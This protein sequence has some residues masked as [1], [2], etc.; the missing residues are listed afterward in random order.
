MYDHLNNNV[1]NIL[2][3]SVINTYLVERCGMHPPTA[4]QYGLAVH[5]HNDFF[6]SIAFPSVAELCLRVNQVGKS[7]VTFEIALF[8]KGVEA[9]KSVGEYVHV[10]VDRHTGRPN[11]DG[12]SL[13]LRQGLQRLVVPNSLPSKL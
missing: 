13:A 8:E 4:P 7:S 6:A 10:F 1:Y 11:P 2:Y 12:M 9:V 3:D 5:S